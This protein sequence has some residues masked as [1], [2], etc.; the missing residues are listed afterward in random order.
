MAPTKTAGGQE[1]SDKFL[2]HQAEAQGLGAETAS[3]HK[4]GHAPGEA[5]VAS[6]SGLPGKGNTFEEAAA[7]TGN[8]TTTNDV[9]LTGLKSAEPGSAAPG[10]DLKGA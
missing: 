7:G 10:P 3:A 4:E 2:K 8:L 1:P 9:G 6:D 5:P